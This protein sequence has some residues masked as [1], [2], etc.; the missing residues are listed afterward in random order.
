MRI[1]ATIRLALSSVL[2][3]A[4]LGCAP[5]P[6]DCPPRPDDSTG[7]LVAIC[8]YVRAKNIDVSPANPA[9]YNIKRI[10]SRTQGTRQVVWVFLDCCYLGDMAVIDPASGEVLSFQAGAK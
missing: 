3:F 5:A 8:R 7:Y 10:E 2:V 4:A 1:Q 9:T 6:R